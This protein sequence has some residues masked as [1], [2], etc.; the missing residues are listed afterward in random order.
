[1]RKPSPSCLSHS[2]VLC[3]VMFCV[4]RPKIRR[5]PLVCGARGTS[6]AARACTLCAR[7]ERSHTLARAPARAA[8]CLHPVA[9]TARCPAAGALQSPYALLAA[10]GVPSR[11]CSLGPLSFFFAAATVWKAVSLRFISA[12]LLV[13]CFWPVLLLFD[14]VSSLPRL[15]LVQFNRLSIQR[16]MYM[17]H[18]YSRKVWPN[19]RREAAMVAER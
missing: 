3:H 19:S 14:C 5:A 11:R 2:R 1:M 16:C 4:D 18:R 10:V 7:A 17:Q 15:R 8:S 6:T 12:I 9:P 13:L